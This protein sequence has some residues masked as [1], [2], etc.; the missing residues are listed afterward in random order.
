MKVDPSLQKRIKY[1]KRL[2]V[3]ES[4]RKSGKQNPNG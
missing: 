1:A 3:L 4:F 2:K